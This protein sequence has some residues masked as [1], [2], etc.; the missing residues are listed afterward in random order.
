MPSRTQ[1]ERW[2]RRLFERLTR[3]DGYQ[4][5]G[6]DLRTME[7]NHPGFTATRERLRQL[8]LVGV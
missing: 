4:P 5:F 2:Y 8:W 6:Y 1:V 7:I 3:G